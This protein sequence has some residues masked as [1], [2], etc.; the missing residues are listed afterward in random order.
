MAQPAKAGIPVIDAANLA[1]SILNIVQWGQQQLQM[2]TTIQNQVS[3][4]QNQTTQIARI[5]GTRNMGQVFNSPQLQTIVPTNVGTVMTNITTQGF[6]GLT[7][8]AQALRTASMIYNCL[9]LQGAQRTSCQGPLSIN[10]QAQAYQNNALQIA[11]QRVQEIQNIQQQINTTTDPMAINQLQAALQ[12]ET[13]Q[14]AND[15]NRLVVAN[16]QMATAQAAAAQAE[17]ERN[18][19]MMIQNAPS[20]ATGFV[21]Q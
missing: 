19:K 20:T 2:V 5:T 18:L 3:Q 8:P 12:A 17:T 16:A 9:D 13:A 4:I 7:N 6:N 21:F 1:Q 10:S 11:S 14:V 15:Q